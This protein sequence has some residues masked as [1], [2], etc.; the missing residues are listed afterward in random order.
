[1]RVRRYDIWAANQRFGVSKCSLRCENLI[2]G[3]CYLP[4]FTYIYSSA[5]KA[6][7]HQSLGIVQYNEPLTTI[8]QLVS[9]MQKASRELLELHHCILT[10]SQKT[11]ISFIH[12]L[13][14]ALDRVV[15]SPL[16]RNVELS[17]FFRTHLHPMMYLLKVLFYYNN[18]AHIVILV[19]V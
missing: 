16:L 6:L 17:L 1:M 12:G 13:A 18:H 19:E 8:Q 3:T 4:T 2:C 10:R 9:S 14:A 11:R 5:F 7:R 15:V